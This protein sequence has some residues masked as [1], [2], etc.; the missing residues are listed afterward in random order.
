MVADE[1]DAANNVEY[2]NVEYDNVEHDNVDNNS[3]PCL[4]YLHLDYGLMVARLR[5]LWRRV[6]LLGAIDSWYRG[7]G[8][9]REL[10]RL[11]P[12]NHDQHDDHADMRELRM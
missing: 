7:R 2:D 10:P 3:V 5:Q 4:V 1:H 6:F 8:S 9:S 11:C 12:A